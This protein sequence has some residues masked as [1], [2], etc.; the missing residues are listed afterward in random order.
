[1]AKF[2]KYCGKELKKGEKCSC[3]KKEIKENN[4]LEKAKETL[5]KEV[6]NSSK[7]YLDKVYTLFRNVFSSEKE[8]LHKNLKEI[9]Y[10]FTL[11][12]LIGASIILSLCTISFLKGIYVMLYAPWNSYTPNVFTQVWN[13]SYFKI[14][15]YITFGIILGSFLLSLIFQLGLEKVSK[16]SIP[17]KSALTAIA[18]SIFDPTI[19]AIISVFLTIFSYKLAIL[20]ILYTIFLFITNLY[21]N[22][23]LIGN[24]ESNHYNRLFTAL[25]L[26]FC[27]L[28]IYL[29]PNL[30]L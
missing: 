10:T 29:I 22:F 14:M 6:S 23:K 25:I 2:C 11:I 21:Q 7:R 8:S 18:I 1:M 15:C 3:D 19:F 24:I 13:L 26:L 28:A 12:L 17:Y 30:F 27:F 5:K 4:E 20:L 16:K 9:D